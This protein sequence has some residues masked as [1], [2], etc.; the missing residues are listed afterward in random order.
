MPAELD[1]LDESAPL[2]ELVTVG[3]ADGEPLR[4]SF[5]SG[6]K[7]IRY[8]VKR[9]VAASIIRELAEALARSSA[10]GGP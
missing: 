5:T 9:A 2:L 3:Y 6:G 1:A 4:M 7:L 8:R 10:S